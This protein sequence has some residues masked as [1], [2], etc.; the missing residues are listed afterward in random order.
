MVLGASRTVFQRISTC[1]WT[2]EYST[3]SMM[4]VKYFNPSPSA[5]FFTFSKLFFLQDEE[6]IGSKV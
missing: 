5:A 1:S 3:L 4:P 6:S 2:N